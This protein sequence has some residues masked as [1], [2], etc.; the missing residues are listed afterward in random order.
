MKQNKKA[1]ISTPSQ[2]RSNY[3]ASGGIR[4][5]AGLIVVSDRALGANI[6]SYLSAWNNGDARGITRY[7]YPGD[8]S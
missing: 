2:H 8:W 6:L 4:A 5:W 3:Y 1:S 7:R